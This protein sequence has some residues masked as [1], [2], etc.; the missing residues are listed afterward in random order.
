MKIFD[1]SGRLNRTRFLAYSN[2]VLLVLFTADSALSTYLPHY[3][4]SA[5]IV[6]PF[7]LTS[8]LTFKF[9]IERYHDV[10]SSGWWTVW[11]ISPTWPIIF[12]ILGMF[13]G[14][15][16]ENRFGPPNQN[17]TMLNKLLAFVPFTIYPLW[18]I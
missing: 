9:A 5:F 15:A 12:L 16:K 11:Y 4:E 1:V 8:L 3:R 7:V 13:P 2:V 10:G 14:S 18:F 17:P 6:I